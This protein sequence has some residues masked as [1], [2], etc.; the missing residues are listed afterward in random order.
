MKKIIALLLGAASAFAFAS[1][2]VSGMIGG[3]TGG[4]ESSSSSRASLGWDY[5]DSEETPEVSETPESSNEGSSEGSNE[6]GHTHTLTK[7]DGVEPT[8]LEKG[9]LTYWTCSDCQLMF[10]DEACTQEITE[11]DIILDKSAHHLTH[12]AEVPYTRTEDGVM[13]HWTCDDCEKYF[14]NETGTRRINQKD[15]IV[16]TPFVIPDFVV[17]IPEGRDPVVLQLTDTQLI[18]ATQGSFSSGYNQ[19]WAPDQREERCFDYLTEVITVANPDFI[20]LTGDMVHGT[21]DHTGTSFLALIEY[22]ESWQIPWAPV[23]GNHEAESKK[24]VDWQCEQLENAKYC[25]FDQKKL[26]GNGNYSVALAQGNKINRV[27]YMMDTN[28]STEASAESLANGHTPNDYCGIKP[29]QI[30][31]CREQLT[32]LK[33]RAPEV[34]VSF[35][36]HIQPMVFATALSQYGFNQNQPQHTINL[37]T[38][39]GVKEGDFG[40]IGRNLIGP[41]DNSNAMFNEMKGLGMDSIFV[42]HVHYNTASVMYN[43][44]RLH[45]GV[46]SSE[47]DQINAIDLTTG[48]ISAKDHVPEGMAPVIGG[49]IITFS[50]EDGSL[51]D[52]HNH[53]CT[54]RS[55]SGKISNGQIHWS[56]FGTTNAKAIAPRK[57]YVVLT[58]QYA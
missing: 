7:T 8:C 18:D 55:G 35:A 12:H 34:K 13:E 51:V 27:F 24:G 52:I 54:D 40:Y 20:I 1:C 30:A 29:D 33:K 26:S 2:D 32:E 57:E 4:E 19:I 45:Y 6:G 10:A 22:M 16:Y 36:Y 28:A 5:F 31:W 47:Y 41:W 14:A 37:D 50:E 15:T 53:Y 43:G 48:V 25:L 23:F 3:L 49:S 17:D 9:S 46:K 11:A 39:A 42:G 21:Y 38:M 58:K 44:V 56:M